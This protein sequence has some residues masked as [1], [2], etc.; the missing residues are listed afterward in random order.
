VVMLHCDDSDTALRSLLNTTD[1]HDVE[2][3][4]RNL[5]DAFIALTAAGSSK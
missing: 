4:A 1:A 3:T 2:V 5:E